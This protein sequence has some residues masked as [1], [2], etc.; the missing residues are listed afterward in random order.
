VYHAFVADFQGQMTDIGTLGGAHSYAYG[1]N[2]W[3]VIVGGS[4]ATAGG[5]MRAFIYRDGVM[6]PLGATLGGP[7]SF[8]FDVNG[9]EQAVGYAQLPGTGGYRAFLHANGST[10]DLGSLGGRSTAYAINEGGV[11]VGSSALSASSTVH[12]FRWQNGVMHDLGTLGGANSHAAAINDDGVVAGW[13][14][15]AQ[16]RKRAVI[17]RDGIITDLNTLIPQGTDW[18]LEGATGVGFQDAIVGWGRRAD[19]QTHGFMLTPPFDVELSVNRHQN[20]LD[21][22]SPNPHEAGTTLRLGASVFNHGHFAPTGLT[23]RD[24]IT[25][26]IEYVSWN[27]GDCAVERAAHSQTLTCTVA[28][29]EFF[30]RDI[31]IEARATGAGP[32]THSAEIL[33]SSHVDSYPPNDSASETNTAV[34]LQSLTLAASTVTGGQP[35]LGRAT[36]TSPAP[37]GGARVTLTSSNPAVAAVPSEFDVLP[38]AFGG[39]ARE[40]YV[41]TKPVSAPVKV[42]ISASYGMVTVTLPLTVLPAGG[43]GPYGGVPRAVPGIIEAEDFDEGGEGAGYHDTSSGNAGGQY[44]RDTDVDIQVTADAQGRYNVGWIDVGE[45]LAYTVKVETAGVYRLDLRVASNG[46]GGR[47]HVEFDGVDKTG[48]MT[49]P[50]TGS[51][52][53]WQDISAPV[54]LAAGAQRMRVVVDGAGA[55][56]VVGNLNYIALTRPPSTPYTGSP[57]PIPG[58]VQA[59][60]FDKGGQGVAYRDGSAGNAGG[61]YRIGE[62]VDIEVTTDAGGGYNVGWM[63]PGEWLAYT[64]NVAAAATYRLDLRIAAFGEGGRVHIE[65]DGVDKTGPMT[66]PNTNGWQSWY[67]LHTHV[68]LKGGQQRMRIVV[69]AAGPTGVVGNV[70]FVHI[71]PLAAPVPSDIVIY[72]VDVPD[73]RIH[74]SWSKQ[75]DS[76]SPGGVKLETTNTGVS[77]VHSPLASPM[78]Y[79]DVTF[80]AV[81]N[82][83]YALWL[84]LKALG[85]N[86]YN[87]AVWVQFSGAH[88]NGGPIHPINSTSGLLVNLATDATASSLSNWGWQNGAYWLVQATTVT[89]PAGGTQTIRIQ[90]REDGVQLD[91]IVLS[92]SAYRHGSPGAVSNDTVIVHKPG[93]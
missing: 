49:I 60:G 83:P 56:G 52:Q 71:M 38:W 48:T 6:S 32:I 72:A 17:W 42:D 74:G 63:A 80:E 2:D 86:K 29:F 67:T 4:E 22:N 24:T 31:M 14:E 37:A 59:E 81:A 21:T 27:G 45:W 20:E 1:V 15:D 87:D 69:D 18:E 79:F 3:N 76:A 44:R 53:K 43:S 35:V 73:D 34:A 46:A 54:T 12:A 68:T 66:I 39:L 51:W 64:V 88:A 25:G 78:H 33:D 47:L 5:P 30:G 11:V 7:E 16:G 92:P 90:V 93:S 13:A 89:F 50:N 65:F 36:L 70:N 85:D 40:F 91:Q 61:V 62:D 55:T 57:A 41:A 10:I 23:I 75:I 82:Q 28:P 84:R 26:P 8:A 58:I 19:G 9:S 77:H